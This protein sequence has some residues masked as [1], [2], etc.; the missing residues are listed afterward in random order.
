[1]KIKQTAGR[2]SLSDFAPTFAKVNDDILFGEVWSNDTLSPKTRSMITITTLVAKGLIDSSFDYHLKTAKDNG[3]S[4]KE[5]G[6]LL[7]HV[8]FYAGWPNAWAAFR[9]AKEVYKEDDTKDGG[10]FGIGEPNTAYA[11]YFV[12]NSYLKPLTDAK[13]TV[14]M[15]N[16]SFEPKC[17]N[18]WHIHHAKS[19]GGQILLC[20][21]GRG[22]YVEEGKDP[23][24][25]F[26]GDVVTIPAGVKHWH[27]AAKDSWF[28]HIAVECPGIETSTE[29]CEQVSD[30]EYNKLK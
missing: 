15:A 19:E 9:K 27:G 16:V 10:M 18:N 17:R 12:G 3:V 6:E 21:S 22:W 24:E 30:T 25:L 26:A 14:F 11:K 2:E 5:M 28:S 1:M 13:K 7:T 29:W 23:Q 20:T 4:K 8:A